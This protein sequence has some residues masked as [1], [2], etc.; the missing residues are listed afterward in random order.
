MMIFLYTLFIY[1]LESIIELIFLVAFKIFNE[2]VGGAII[3]VSLFVNIVT[4]PIYAAAEEWQNKERLLQKKLKNKIKD[5][6]AVF[7]GDERYMILSAYYRQ[8]NY[9]PLYSLRGML[10]LL[11]Q[12]PFFIAAYHFLSELTL[13]QGYNFLFLPNLGKP[14]ALLNILSYKI[15]F[16]PILMTLVNL[17]SVMIYTKDF[18]IKEKIQ[19]Y[20]MALIFLFLLYD[21]PSGLVFYWT[22]NNIFSLGKNIFAKF[23][24]NKKIWYLLGLIF[25]VTGGVFFITRAQKPIV[26]I[27]IIGIMIMYILIP[28]FIKLLKYF[29]NSITFFKDIKAVNSLFYFSIVS[30]TVLLGAVIPSSLVASSVQEFSYTIQYQN[31]FY[32]LWI[33][34]LQGCGFLFIWPAILYRLANVRVKPFFSFIAFIFL[35]CS[36]IN[37]FIFQ[38]NYGSL[39]GFL[40]FAT[41]EVL[42]H[43]LQENVINLLSLFLSIAL[44]VVLLKYKLSQKSIFVSKI[45][46]VSF[47]TLSCINAVK[48]YSGYKNVTKLIKIDKKNKSIGHIEKVYGFT[49]TGKN[50]LVFMLD[51]M[52]GIFIPSIFDDFPKI[53]EN[54]TGFTLYPNTISFGGHTYIGAPA[55][56]GGYEYTPASFRKNT[57]SNRDM[58]NE[59]LCVMPRLFSESGWNTV[60]TDASLANHSWIPDNSIFE[61]YDGVKAL[62]MEGK[63]VGEWIQ[64]HKIGIQHKVLPFSETLRNTI[65]FSFLKV[66]PYL[67]RKRLYNKGRYLQSKP[68][69]YGLFDFVAKI[70]PLEFIKR[71]ISTGYDKDCFNLIVNN[72][73]HTPISASQARLFCSDDFIK[74]CEERS[75]N[76]V[77]LNH[78]IS[79]AY[80][81]LILGDMMKILKENGVYDNTRIIFVADHGYGNLILNNSI[82]DTDFKDKTLQQTYYMPIL[83]M[84]D[85]NASG[86]LNLNMDFMTNADVPIMATSG[87]ENITL[88]TKNPFTGKTFKETKEKTEIVIGNFLEDDILN[89]YLKEKNIFVES[90]WMKIKK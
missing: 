6:K 64:K 22:L 3:I 53:S 17:L 55:L 76:E 50:V 57:D 40:S 51:R 87:F 84:K 7:K 10:G 27:L 66:S 19:L 45:L 42:I 18:S 63:Y 31:P 58:Y 29:I 21:S 90:N 20:I 89:I 80:L 44:I 12:I 24:Y 81:F 48:I 8:N 70:A 30:I 9:H 68:S 47:L 23:K 60:I 86:E 37:V 43:S 46:L 49:K 14:D 39:T 69:A 54:F 38:G 52:P 88:L 5:I 62:N 25:I 71:D 72:V 79:D 82:F 73:S 83:M 77:T 74:K 41:D 34:L 33:T 75:A 4:L 11:V 1:P 36:V 15:N 13:L 26:V 56:Y 67:V 16:L 59:S 78:Y 85:F 35:V 32:L 2:N 65:R 28:F 61:P